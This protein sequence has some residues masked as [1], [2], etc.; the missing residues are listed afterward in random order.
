MRHDRY[1]LDLPKTEM[2]YLRQNAMRTPPARR[3]T[4]SDQRMPY[5]PNTESHRSQRRHHHTRT[6]DSATRC[7]VAH[8]AHRNCRPHNAASTPHT[9][10]TANATCNA[11]QTAHHAGGAA[12][13]CT[14]IAPATTTTTPTPCAATEHQTQAADRS[15]SITQEAEHDTEHSATTP[16]ACS[17]DAATNKEATAH[18]TTYDQPSPA[19]PTTTPPQP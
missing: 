16:T 17:T 14:E 4:S 3:N 13:Q 10:T 8:V 5:L 19:P 18:T 12:D 7:L 1:L 2:P 9:A 6:R 11:T 15:H